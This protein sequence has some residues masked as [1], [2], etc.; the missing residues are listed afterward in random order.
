MAELPTG[1]RGPGAVHEFEPEV[2]G[3]L[4]NWCSYAGADLA[5]TSRLAYPTNLRVI[6]VMCSGRVDPELMLEPFLHGAD[7]VMVLGCHPGDC[8]YLTGNHQ[9]EQRVQTMGMVLEHLG[10]E[11]GRLY[12]DWVSAA[13]G[14]RFA[15][16]VADFVS[17]VKSLGP[18]GGAGSKEGLSHGEFVWRVEVARRVV[19]GER[20]RWL[21]GRR[22][23]LTEEE[24]VYGEKVSLERATVLMQSVIADECVRAAI[25]VLAA[26]SP[27]SVKD[28]AG[29]LGLSSQIVLE[30]A[31]FLKRRGVIEVYDI[32]DR[33]PRYVRAGA[34]A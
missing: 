16:L 11:P 12:L 33:S 2:V 19:E 8:H 21:V 27:V 3:F 6:R 26:R 4:C 20:F 28:V 30:H 29:R 13:E 1:E 23:A 9:A 14:A 15:D 32:L 10:I 25:E 17:R 5:G 34:R 31:A 24:N 18:A 22:K 7:G